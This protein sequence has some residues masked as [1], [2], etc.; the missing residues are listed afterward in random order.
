MTETLHYLRNAKQWELW[1]HSLLWV[2]QDVY[3]RPYGMKGLEFQAY[4]ARVHTPT[5]IIKKL[6]P[7]EGLIKK[8]MQYG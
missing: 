3:H 1:L 2:M 5:P 4:P 8:A 7:L 6:C